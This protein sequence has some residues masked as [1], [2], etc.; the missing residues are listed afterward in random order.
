MYTYTCAQPRPRAGTRYILARQPGKL[1]AL[2]KA[3][4]LNPTPSTPNPQPY[5]LSPKPSTLNPQATPT[6]TSSGSCPSC[7][8]RLGLF[9]MV[10]V[11]GYLSIYS[12]IYAFPISGFDGTGAVDTALPWEAFGCHVPS[13]S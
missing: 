4:P 7:D 1:A 2:F 8:L 11:S 5:T 12:S 13:K 3:S 9:A 6:G 10:K